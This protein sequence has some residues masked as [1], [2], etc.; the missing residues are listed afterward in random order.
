M[1]H[2]TKEHTPN[3]IHSQWKYHYKLFTIHEI[4]G[5]WIDGKLYPMKVSF[6][7]FMAHG[8]LEMSS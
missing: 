5:T 7:S 6:Y 3:H 4:H 1:A 2:E 8:I